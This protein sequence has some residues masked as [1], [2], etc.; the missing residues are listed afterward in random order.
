MTPEAPTSNLPETM[1]AIF[2]AHGSPFLLDDQLWMGE[3]KSWSEAMPR[4]RAIL[5]ISAHWEERPITLGATTT[6]PLVYDF[7][8]FPEKYY[9]VQYPAPGAPDL[10]QRVREL[11]GTAHVTDDPQRGLD[12]G[13][14]IPLKVM[15]PHADVPVLQMS[16]PT[17][18]P[19]VLFELGRAL[20]PL[21]KEGVLIIGSG[22]LI[23]NLRMFSFRPIAAPEW[24]HEFDH[25]AADVF[26]RKDVDALLDYRSKAPAIN[27]ALPTHEHFLPSIVTM[28]ATSGIEEPVS[29]PITGF[30]GG[31]HTKRSVQFG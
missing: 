23:H 18:N 1:P 14:Y 6:V 25:W 10:A 2:L 27:I 12:H 7:Y 30:V 22:F 15:Y 8:G 4:P 9:Q 5:M 17:Q 20:A 28:G 26:T 29:F 16:I 21:R 13:A 31:P 24:A 11:L 19:Q 3:L